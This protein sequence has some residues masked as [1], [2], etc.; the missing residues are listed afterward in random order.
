MQILLITPSFFGYERSIADAFR[1]AGHVVDVFDERPSNKAWARAAV[2]VAPAVLSYRIARHYRSLVARI[3]SADYDALLVVKGEVVPSWF[4]EWFI[5]YNPRAVRAYY[6]FDSLSNSPQGLR[7][8]SRFDH[9]FSFDPRDVESHPGFRYKPLFYSTEYAP[10]GAARDLDISFVGTLHGDRYAFTQAVASGIP[11]ERK[12]LYYFIPAAWFFWLRKL[13]SGDVRPVRRNDVQTS[14]LS[15]DDT[16]R[17][18]Q[19]SKAVIDVQRQGQAGLTMRT[20][21]ALATG[22]ALIT[23]NEAVRGEAFFD[24]ARVLVTPRDPDLIDP[25]EIERFTTMQPAVGV[26]PAGFDDY[27]LASW[28]D[29]F[30]DV[31]QQGVS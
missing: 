14:P 13:T 6:T 17:L 10:S 4:L 3:E 7:L 5:E 19:R 27:S 15:R 21:E 9:K 1:A 2:R 11:G 16:V 31:F 24:P 29:E 28:V 25:A 20:F 26:A 30:I 22:A 23:A 18:M 12:L 8:L